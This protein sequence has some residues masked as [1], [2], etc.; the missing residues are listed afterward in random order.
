MN[1]DTKFTLQIGGIVLLTAAAGLG[2]FLT[3]GS[4]AGVY[5]IGIGL[6]LVVVG[7][8]VVY[9]R[10]E[11]PG[12]APQTSRFFE[13]KAETV[14][15][16]MRSLLG[17]YDRLDDRFSDW[18]ASDLDDEL[19]YALDQFAD[20]GVEFDRATNRFDVVGDGEVRDLERLQERVEELRTELGASAARH[21]ERE[22]EACRDAQ[23]SLVDAGLVDEVTEP[24][25]VEGE[26]PEELLA[27]V[28]VF[29]ECV[30]DALEEAVESLYEV[31]D[32]ND[33][34]NDIVDAGAETA[35]S[36]LDRG[37]YE[38]VAN[39]L[40]ETRDDLE[41]DLSADFEAE[42][43]ILASLLDTV[44][45]SVVD[46]YVSRSLVADVEDVQRELEEIDTALALSDLESLTERATDSATAMVAE[47]AAELGEDMETLAAADVPAD[48]YEYQE[49][50]DEAYIDRLQAADDVEAFRSEWL[51]AVGELSVALDAVE[52]KA[53]IASAY[54]DIAGEIDTTLRETGR[55]EPSD[56]QVKQPG[57]F[58]E[59][60]ASE[61]EGATYEPSTP[62]VV[63]DDFG[64]SYDV[65]VTAGFAEGGEE[66]PVTVSL[67][68]S[69]FDASETVET[70]LLEVVTFEGVPY[71]EYTFSVSTSEEGYAAVERSV[72]VDGATEFEARLEETTLRETVCEGVEVD[73]RDAL[74]DA[75]S[76]FEDRYEEEEYASTAMAL[77]MNDEYVPCML[78]LWADDE[79]LTA[80]RDDDEILVYDHE[81]F[82]NRLLN[83]VE[84][85]LSE[86]ESISYDEIRNRY[87]SVPAS[88]ELIVET[89]QGTSADVDCG[90]EELSR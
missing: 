56:L 2:V 79:G 84:H 37:E 71:G 89:L 42:Q 85:S 23:R 43:D 36:A 52:E 1:D 65:D 61:T 48:F 67:D 24:P 34:P 27:T 39:G 77:P 60:Y 33:R 6:P 58:M 17:E 76:L 72:V 46:E 53:A 11:R 64:E 21:V 5:A 81:Q 88:R 35:R 30:A 3:V 51:T 69:S 50:S 38:R 54:G 62:A 7:S 13:D 73:A 19:R 26:D 49:A 86:G 12:R 18:D 82:T 4:E 15:E 29:D 32:A 8:A 25:V 22:R 44:T 20:A 57:D 75:A 45:S 80:C 63:A 68:G 9:A 74:G 31:A 59:L 70:H 14:A 83:I 28:D 90:P 55:V 40:L 47:M 41:R 78:A 66:R 16:R 10:R 87:L